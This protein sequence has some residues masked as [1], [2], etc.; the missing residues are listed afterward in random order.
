MKIAWCTDVH[1]NFLTDPQI[2]AFVDTLRKANPDVLVIT[3][4]VAESH[5]LARTL[6]LLQE[7]FGKPCYFVLGNHDFYGSS[8]RETEDMARHLP[9][10][11]FYLSA[12]EG[13]DLGNGAGLVGVDGWYDGR[14]GSLDGRISMSD[15]RL[16]EDYQYPDCP[17][18]LW[19]CSPQ[20][21]L[22]EVMKT[23]AD[24]EARKALDKLRK[25][26]ER[27]Q[28]IYF[29]THIPPFPGVCPQTQ[30]EYLP[31]M[32]SVAMGNSLAQVAEEFPEVQFTVLCGHTHEAVDY[33]HSENLRVL[34]GASEYGFP[35]FLLLRR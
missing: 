28:K 34:V 19:G 3:G 18:E 15:F 6:G 13:V 8:F 33:H 7:T 14:A 24:Q 10:G 20:Y 2:V 1:L 35:Q 23:R 21:H 5:S 17:K 12:L 26:A 32:T 27:Y 9:T 30:R 22:Q 25:A 11:L 31:Y 4:D 16:I 29:G